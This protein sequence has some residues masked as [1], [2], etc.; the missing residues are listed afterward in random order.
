MDLIGETDFAANLALNARVIATQGRINAFA[1]DSNFQPR[2]ATHEFFG[3]EVV[4]RFVYYYVF[5]N[6][7][8]DAAIEA[9]TELLEQGRLQR[10]VAT[11][12]PLRAVAEAHVAVEQGACDGKWPKNADNH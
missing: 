1:S 11:Q 3:K 4:V 6:A 2:V 5:P 7:A 8:F 9:I 12:F 10:P